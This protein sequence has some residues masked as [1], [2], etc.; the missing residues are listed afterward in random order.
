MV[1]GNFHENK[2]KGMN[3]FVA[4][5]DIIMVLAVLAAVAG[6]VRRT[7]N[8]VMASTRL[9]LG[10]LLFF[11][12]LYGT[13]LAIEWLGIT[14]Q[15]DGFE[16]YIGALLP[17]WWAFVFYAFLRETDL[18]DIK[19]LNRELE[20][21]VESL[22]EAE[23]RFRTIFQ[24]ASDGILIAHAVG[25][26]FFSANEKMCEMLGYTKD[27]LSSMNVSDIHPKESISYVHQQFA[28]IAAKEVP[29]VQNIPLLKK[30]KTVFF[31]DISGS[32]MT[33][34]KEDY[35]IG[36]FR[37]I[38]ER[39]QAEE[40]LRK[41]QKKFSSIFHLNPNPLA[42]TDV[43]TGNFMDV[44]EAFVQW[45]GYSREETIGAS[46]ND[47][48]LWVN[49]KDREKII[50]TLTETG[51]ANGIEIVMR[52][53]NGHVRNVLFSARFIEV[54]QKRYLLTL[55]HDITERK[56]A[57]EKY[58]NIFDNAIEGIYQ[59]TLDGKLITA[60]KALARMTGYESP[61]ALIES[62]NDIKKQL[63]VHPEEWERFLNI[64]KEKNFV[65]GFEIE[66]YRKN[67]SH[68]WVGINAVAVRNEKGEILYI[69]GLLEDVSLRKEAEEKLRQSLEQLRRAIN[70]TIQVLVSAL[71]ARDPYTTG[72]QSR[73]TNLACTIAEEMELAKEQIEGIRMAGI[74]H[75]I[76]KLSVPAEILSKPT[77][78]TTL[79]Y[80]LIKQHS[81]NGFEMLKNVES[82]WPLAQI[83]YQHHE[84]M[85]G[86]GYPRKLKGDEI[87][88][89]ARILAVADVVEAM[90]S[91]RP[92]RPSL[93]IDVALEEIEKN[94]GILYDT[95][96]VDA[97]IKLFREKGYHL[98]DRG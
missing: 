15:L 25:K 64:L 53:K 91:H 93:G 32:A 85:N 43:A 95:A 78:L 44:N 52:L 3:H 17:M 94:R 24:S 50:K 4:I 62:I 79:E 5:L 80:D 76:G 65:Y 45:T 77:R 97:C 9:L 48:H 55:A 29:V 58:R 38:T 19:A 18:R 88:L 42:I 66:L 21:H 56:R 23:L 33:L 35:L 36:I 63:S 6:L 59:I 26:H 89:E 10:C 49:P 90:A 83:V 11:M 34:D 98:T 22:K 70:T 46:S 51:D 75:D 82:P 39:K 30:D 8:Y 37:D 20:Q 92:Y 60:N 41:S 12:L 96:A 61:E 69:E 31:A 71:E 2:G 84:R 14:T 74:I 68:F 57:E 54:E 87:L 47:L 13:C 73:A 86:T 28:R 81:L 67:K 16:D 27:E 40:N 7:N 1:L 72:H